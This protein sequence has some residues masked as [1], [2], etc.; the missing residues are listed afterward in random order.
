MKSFGI[1]VVLIIS[2]AV[3]SAETDSSDKQMRDP[4]LYEHFSGMKKTQENLSKL[5]LDEQQRLQPKIRR[6]ERAA[7]QRLRK[8]KQEGVGSEDYR[9]QGGEEFVAYVQQFERYCETLR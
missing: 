7:C 9:G 4:E 8:D 6:A 2:A 1:L 3:C 5:S